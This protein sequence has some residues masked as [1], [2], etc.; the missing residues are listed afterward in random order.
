MATQCMSPTHKWGYRKFSFVNFLI[1]GWWLGP[2]GTF[3]LWPTLWSLKIFLSKVGI[4][5]WPWAI[6]QWCWG[7]YWVAQ[8][9]DK[10]EESSE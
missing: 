10:Q 2:F 9:P 6:T 8:N 3:V 4:G 1:R 7:C 5:I